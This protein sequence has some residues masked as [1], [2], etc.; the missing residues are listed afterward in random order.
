LLASNVSLKSL[1][2]KETE[3]SKEEKP[4]QNVE[5]VSTISDE[6]ARMQCLSTK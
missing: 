3:N 6:Q 2:E 4:T 5:V 1:Q